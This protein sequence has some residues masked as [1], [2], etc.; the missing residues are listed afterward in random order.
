MNRPFADSRPVGTLR[1]SL[2]VYGWAMNVPAAAWPYMSRMKLGHG[3]AVRIVGKPDTE[4]EYQTGELVRDSGKSGLELS[5][6]PGS[7]S[8]AFRVRSSAA[9]KEKRQ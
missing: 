8:E 4:N 1:E 5:S 3:S 6:V 7:D 2:G 9:G